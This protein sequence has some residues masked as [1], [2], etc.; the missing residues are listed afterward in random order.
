MSSDFYVFFEEFPYEKCNKSYPKHYCSIY[1]F[2]I[3]GGKRVKKAIIYFSSNFVNEFLSISYIFP[4]KRSKMGKTSVSH[5]MEVFYFS[6]YFWRG[7]LKSFLM[8]NA[9]KLTPVL[10]IMRVN[11]IITVSITLLC[12]CTYQNIHLLTFHLLTFC[13]RIMLR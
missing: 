4:N 1:W 8:I 9:T 5:D 11:M 3:K 13:G 7:F 6:S 12:P 2:L 10:G